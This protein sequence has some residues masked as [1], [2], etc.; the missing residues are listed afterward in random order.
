[1]WMAFTTEL[2]ETSGLSVK[3]MGF[4]VNVAVTARAEVIETVQPPVPVQAPLQPVNVDPVAGAAVTVTVVPL[5]ND[6]AHVLPQEMPVGVLV[7]VPLPVPDFVTVNANEAGSVNVAVTEVA[8]FI[9]T[10]HVPVPAQPP[11]L[12]P[13]NVDPPAGVAVRVTTVPV[14]KA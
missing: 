7:T 12:Q 8:A 14:V 3:L 13:E 9:V 1:M 2:R 5:A 6:V 11:P 10:A 4:A